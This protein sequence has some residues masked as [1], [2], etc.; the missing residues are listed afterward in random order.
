MEQGIM[1]TAEMIDAL[2]QS[3]NDAVGAIH[4]GEHIRFCKLMYGMVVR[5]AQL[6]DGVSQDI[7]SRDNTIAVLEQRL[8]DSGIEVFHDSPE[9]FM[10]DAQEDG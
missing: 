6:R 1:G 10:K 7:K 5:L 3:C 4:A 9:A 8:K 2:I